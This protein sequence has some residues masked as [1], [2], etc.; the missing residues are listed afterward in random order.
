MNP[1]EPTP[2][3]APDP[4]SDL[5]AQ[6]TGGL[7][8]SSSSALVAGSRI[9]TWVLALAAGLAAGVFAWAIGEA[10]IIPEMDRM[11]ARGEAKV[12]PSMRGTHNGLVSFGVLGAALGLG[13]GLAGGMIKRSYL[14]ACLA[15]LIGLFLGGGVAVVTSWLILPVYYKH[16]TA[17][18][19]TYSLMVHGGVWAAVGGAAGLAFGLGL[20]GW[21]RM[22][23]ATVGGAGAALFATVVYEFA[24]GIL[25][26]LALTNQPVSVTWQSRL[27]ARLLVAV[28]VVAGAVLSAGSGDAGQGAGDGKT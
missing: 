11:T 22:L 27:A 15:A 2:P 10:T 3:T 23:R 6:A 13:L 4:P 25:S 1:D 12:P 14:R 8:T 28:L 18:D 26:P 7:P 24:G 16:L 20:G 5:A 19:L 21:G 17:D 9:R